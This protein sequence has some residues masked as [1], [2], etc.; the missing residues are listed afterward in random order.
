MTRPSA[1]CSDGAPGKETVNPSDEETN[2]VHASR[3]FAASP[4]SWA[5]LPAAG[6]FG[7]AAAGATFASGAAVFEQPGSMIVAV[8]K[9]VAFKHRIFIHLSSLKRR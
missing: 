3:D 8:N 7:A 5:A 2:S 6:V 1:V 4:V 9:A